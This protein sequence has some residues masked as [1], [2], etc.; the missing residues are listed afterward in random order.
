LIRDRFPQTRKNSSGYALDEFLVSDR[1]IDLVIGAEGT[2]G[3]VSH[4]EWRLDRIPAERAGLRIGL[5]SLDQLADVVQSIDTLAPSASELL[6]RSFLDLVG[7]ERGYGVEAVLLVEFERENP[8]ELRQTLE[9]ATALARPLSYSVDTAYSRVAAERLWSIRHAASP[10]LARL[11]DERRSLQVIEDACVPLPLVSEYIRAVRRAATGRDLPVV[12]FGHAG[13]GHIH[14][15]LLPDVTRE[16][17]EANVSGL[18]EEVTG[19]VVRLG[20]TLT[21]E[22]GDGRLRAAGLERIYGTDI[23][24]LFRLVKDSFDPAGIFNPGVIISSGD[25]PISRLKVGTG[26]VRLPSDIADGLREIERTG[27]YARPRL[28]LAGAAKVGAG[29]ELGAKS[30]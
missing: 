6:D 13:D 24:Q 30:S 10:I 29:P 8:A 22:H 4:I 25:S 12:I 28:E 2:L 23:L 17:W 21:G 11:P 1:A 14:V 9:A 3:V 27:G 16:G 18:L 15:N 7:T 5:R 19:T 26:A 20:G